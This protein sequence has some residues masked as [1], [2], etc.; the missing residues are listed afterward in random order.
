[1]T[2]GTRKRICVLLQEAQVDFLGSLA[3]RLE[4]EAHKKMS[5]SRII[6]V[7]T[8]TLTGTKPDIGECRTEEEIERELLKGLKK[9]VKEL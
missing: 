1:M 4:K 6:E 9:A 7:L 8:K 2:S 5:R 3:K